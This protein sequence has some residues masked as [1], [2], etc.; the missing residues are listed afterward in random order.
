MVVMNDRSSAP[1][2]DYLA[3]LAAPTPAPGG[4]SAAAICAAAAAA[5]VAMVAGLS[6]DRDPNGADAARQRA[7]I[8]TA[9]AARTKLTTLANDDE[10]AY[11]AF[12]AA[13]RLPKGDD[14]AR[15]A[16]S[17]ALSRAALTAA[18]VPLRVIEA[19]ADVA[20]A[21]SSLANRTIAAAAASASRERKSGS[22]PTPRSALAVR[23]MNLRRVSSSERESGVFMRGIIKTEASRAPVEHRACHEGCTPIARA[24]T[25]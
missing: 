18:Q 11:G 8:A 14:A 22:S 25:R 17:D 23:E 7:A 2:A 24:P 1:L 13:L 9:T 16:R 15:A 20:E 12:I 5:L 4:G 21:A 3:A 19:C 6:L 10:V